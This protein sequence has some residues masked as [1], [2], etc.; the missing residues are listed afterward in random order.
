[1]SESEIQLEV[2]LILEECADLFWTPQHIIKLYNWLWLSYDKFVSYV[3]REKLLYENFF[4][5][6]TK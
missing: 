5:P 6:I 3:E 4:V 1:M 2:F